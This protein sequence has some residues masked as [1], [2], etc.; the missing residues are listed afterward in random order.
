M[1]ARNSPKQS[2]SLLIAQLLLNRKISSA[3][4]AGAYLSP[5]L[6]D[7]FRGRSAGCEPAASILAEAIRDRRRIIL[8]GDYDV[9]GA[10]GCHSLACAASRG[11]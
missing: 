11:R 10:T 7:L 2:A 9:D 6:K 8:Y 4:E 1:D 3:N 5:Q